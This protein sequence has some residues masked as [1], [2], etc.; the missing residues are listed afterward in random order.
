ML[1]Y[2]NFKNFLQ[3]SCEVIKNIWITYISTHPYDIAS[4][5]VQIYQ[6]IRTC[7]SSALLY[8]VVLW[9][10]FQKLRGA[11]F[12]EDQSIWSA[13]HE[14]TFE[15]KNPKIFCINIFFL[16]LMLL[17]NVIDHISDFF[18][19]LCLVFSEEMRIFPGLEVFHVLSAPFYTA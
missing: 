14:L 8:S 5:N 1:I 7:I 4:N 10:I 18:F 15:K 17:I 9:W 13:K 16:L 12:L 6:N 19:A 3:L 11:K 2:Y